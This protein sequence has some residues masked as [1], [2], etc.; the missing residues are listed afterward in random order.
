MQILHASSSRKLAS[1]LAKVTG[2]ESIAATV[3]RFPDGET[4]HFG[5][6]SKAKAKELG[7]EVLPG[8]AW[9]EQDVDIL[10]PAATL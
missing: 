9:I 7:Y 1:D 6:I 8:E 2:T 3:K 4:D 10:I 5:G